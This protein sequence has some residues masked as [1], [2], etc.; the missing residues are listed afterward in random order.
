MATAAGTFRDH[1]AELEALVARPGHGRANED[2]LA[3]ARRVLEGLRASEEARDAY[4]MATLGLIAARRLPILYSE[5]A[6]Q[7]HE[8]GAGGIRDRALADCREVRSRLLRLRR[9]RPGRRGS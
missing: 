4:V 6:H 8:G 5:R 7:G 2:A 1:L 3:A 9:E